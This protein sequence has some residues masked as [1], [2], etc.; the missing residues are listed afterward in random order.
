[1]ANFEILE[2]Y[3][4]RFPGMG[5]TITAAY[6]EEQAIDIAM[7]VRKMPESMRADARIVYHAAL[8]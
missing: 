4:V 1:M 3:D 5:D 7:K 2:R 6:S 8:D